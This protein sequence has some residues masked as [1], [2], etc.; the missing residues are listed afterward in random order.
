M[1]NFSIVFTFD[2]YVQVI[3]IEIPENQVLKASLSLNARL[4]SIEIDSTCIAAS[5]TINR[6]H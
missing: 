4:E 5:M 1:G 3:L 2:D 6:K